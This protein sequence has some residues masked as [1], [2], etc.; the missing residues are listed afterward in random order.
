MSC[1]RKK[2]DCTLCLLYKCKGGNFI[3][4]G[5]N[6]KPTKYKNDNITLCLKGQLTNRNIE[7]TVEEA[8]FIASALVSTVGNLAPGILEK[9]KCLK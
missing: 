2:K 5:I 3:C 7:M 1:P 8:C 4:S 9:P 6:K